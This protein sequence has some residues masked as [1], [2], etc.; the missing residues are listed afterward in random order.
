[1]NG[2]SGNGPARRGDDCELRTGHNVARRIYV[3]HRG[4]IVLPGTGRR[5]Y[6]GVDRGF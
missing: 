1:M 5:V 2:D 3:L 6:V 4:V